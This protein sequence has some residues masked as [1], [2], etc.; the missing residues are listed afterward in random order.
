MDANITCLGW[1]LGAGFPLVQWE[2]THQHREA[3]TVTVVRVRFRA[4]GIN[5]VY[6]HTCV[7]LYV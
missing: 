3:G 4:S 2:V 1:Q 5:H 7:C 6:V